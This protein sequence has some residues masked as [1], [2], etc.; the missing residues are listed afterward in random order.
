[1]VAGA[2]VCHTVKLEVC[3]E[4]ERVVARVT[5]KADIIAQRGGADCRLNKYEYTLLIA[6]IK[7]RLGSVVA[8]DDNTR[9]A[10]I[11]MGLKAQLRI[12]V[13]QF[14][15]GL[16]VVYS[17]RIIEYTHETLY[18]DIMI[19]WEHKNGKFVLECTVP[20]GTTATVWLPSDKGRKAYEIKS[21]AYKFISELK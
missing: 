21:G 4:P 3:I 17:Q 19:K 13:T 6:A 7:Q 18:G 12:V 16:A 10:A 14:E 15:G 9:I 8:R 1:M 11:C 20:V 5:T 2:I